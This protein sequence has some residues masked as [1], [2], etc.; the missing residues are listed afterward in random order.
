MFNPCNN[1][2]KE[3]NTWNLLIMSVEIIHGNI[4]TLNIAYSRA[5]EKEIHNTRTDVL[6]KRI[7]AHNSDFE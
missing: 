1:M 6:K 5:C 3:N 7:L 2:G 4:E